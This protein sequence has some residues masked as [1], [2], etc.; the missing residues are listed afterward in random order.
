MGSVAQGGERDD[1]D[2]AFLV[3]A[4]ML[5]R[6]DNDRHESWLWVSRGGIQ[7]CLLPQPDEASRRL[8]HLIL[9]ELK[10][11]LVS[12]NSSITGASTCSEGM[13]VSPLAAALS[14]LRPVAMPK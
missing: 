13:K 14:T 12:G 6:S 11:K 5:S 4:R 9:F 3:V 2:P 7:R 8:V 10:L 1:E